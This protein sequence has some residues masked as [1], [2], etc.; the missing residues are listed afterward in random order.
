MFVNYN[1]DNSLGTLYNS[2]QAYYV[3]GTLIPLLSL[4]LRCPQYFLGRNYFSDPS[5]GDFSVTYTKAGGFNGDTIDGLYSL[6]L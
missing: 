1:M 5:I 4:R 3:G 6:V 2:N